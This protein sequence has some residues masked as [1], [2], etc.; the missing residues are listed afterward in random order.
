MIFVLIAGT[1]TP[2]ALLVLDGTLAHGVLIVVWAGAA[3]RDRVELVWIDA[4]A[5]LIAVVYVALGW[6]AVAAMPLADEL[7]GPPGSCWRSA[8][9]S[10]RRRRGLRAQAPRPVAGRVRLPRDLP[11]VRG[12][13]RRR[14]VRR[15]RVLGDPAP[16]PERSGPARDIDLLYEAY[17][18]FNKGDTKRHGAQCPSGVLGPP[19]GRSCR[20]LETYDGAEGAVE[21][22]SLAGEGFEDYKIEPDEIF[23][24]RQDVVVVVATQSGRGT[25]S[26]AQVDGTIVHLWRMRD[27]K[28]VSMH[29]YSIQ[30]A[31][32]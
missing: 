8:A 19:I 21:A 23:E 27:G 11:R 17:G 22:A 26:G 6:V 31:G 32:A 15:R 24:P 9:C 13:G 20:T 14:A 1:Y 3:R 25:A 28:A 16:S 2:F 29:A 5:W 30:G 18:D 7:G 4:P 10:T 12:R